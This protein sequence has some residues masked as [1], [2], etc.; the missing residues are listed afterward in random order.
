MPTENLRDFYIKAGVIDPDPVIERTDAPSIEGEAARV[1]LQ[2]IDPD[3]AGIH[4][5]SPRG[6]PTRRALTPEEKQALW[7]RAFEADPE[8]ASKAYMAIPATEN[9]KPRA[10]LTEAEQRQKRWDDAFEADPDAAANAYLAIGKEPTKKEPEATSKARA[11][12]RSRILQRRHLLAK[13]EAL[14]RARALTNCFQ[15]PWLETK[16]L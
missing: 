9:I 8:E 4:R 6:L 11:K 15:T 13:L 12:R 16:P 14:L 5:L 10:P 3:F 2:A 1:R 7:D